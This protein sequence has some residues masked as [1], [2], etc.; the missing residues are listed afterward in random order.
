VTKHG[1][2]SH[3]RTATAAGERPF[4]GAL[5]VVRRRYA[6]PRFAARPKEEHAACQSFVDGATAF[7]RHSTDGCNAAPEA[8]AKRLIE[9]P[10]EQHYA[11]LD[12]LAAFQ[13]AV[14]QLLERRR[15]IDVAGAGR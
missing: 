13:V 14:L 12:Q 9:I 4:S 11:F 15:E 6:T 7:I 10:H 3:R 8:P 1:S 5:G 2:L